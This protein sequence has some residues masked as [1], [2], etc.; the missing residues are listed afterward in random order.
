M[1]NAQRFPYV[2]IQN[3][4]GEILLR[5]YLPVML[6]H[7]DKSTSVSALLD[8][9][10]DVNV[11]PYPV[12]LQLGAVWDEQRVALELSGNLANYEARGLIITVTIGQFSPVRLAFAWTQAV[13]VPLILGQ[14][15]FFAEFDVCFFRS[16][17][18]FEISPQNVVQRE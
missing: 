14:V 12:G 13:T 15:N 5:P 1:D 7:S 8:T 6:T 3:A 16:Q 10:A 4:R 9:G 11:L 17:S 2:P 18:A